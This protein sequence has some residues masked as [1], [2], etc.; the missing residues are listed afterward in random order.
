M[1]KRA[2]SLKATPRVV[3]MVCILALVS[4]VGALRL[5]DVWPV[6]AAVCGVVFTL[7][8]AWL[9]GYSIEPV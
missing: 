7:L 6:V 4:L 5:V 3:V 1:N 8:A 2:S 9:A